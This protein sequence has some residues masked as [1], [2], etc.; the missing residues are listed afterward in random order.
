MSSNFVKQGPKSFAGG[1]DE[2]GVVT[3][4]TPLQNQ[5]IL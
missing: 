4:T 3:A 2:K 5:L 1:A